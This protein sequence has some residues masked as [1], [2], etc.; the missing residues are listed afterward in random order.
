[1]NN[2]YVAQNMQSVFKF[3]IYF[4]YWVTYDD[5]KSLF[6]WTDCVPGKADL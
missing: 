4:G 3:E 1:M 2:E 5:F 6:N